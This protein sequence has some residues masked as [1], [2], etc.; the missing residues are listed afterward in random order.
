MDNDGDKDKDID[1]LFKRTGD[2]CIMT[3]I[4]TKDTNDLLKRNGT[5]GS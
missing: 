1:I 5:F 3:L 2:L 4:M